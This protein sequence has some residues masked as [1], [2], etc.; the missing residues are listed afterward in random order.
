MY[1]SGVVR[2]KCEIGTYCNLI[3]NV[4]HNFEPCQQTWTAEEVK[5]T[6][7]ADNNDYVL[8]VNNLHEAISD[9]TFKIKESKITVTLVKTKEF[10]WYQLTKTKA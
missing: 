1:G 2:R 6:V 3:P 4:L 9:A 10:S 7:C 5:L 8:I